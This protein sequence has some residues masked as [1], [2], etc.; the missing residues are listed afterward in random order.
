MKIYNFK[1]IKTEGGRVSVLC[2]I[3]LVSEFEL[4]SRYS[5]NFRTNTLEKV[6]QL[7]EA[8]EYTDCTSAEG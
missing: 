2:S 6:A 7:A 4:Q 8:V 5:V 1:Q 3:V